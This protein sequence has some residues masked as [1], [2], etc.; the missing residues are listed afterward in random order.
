MT[1]RLIRRY[2]KQGYTI[3]ELWIDGSY[4]C[5]T[6]EP[7]DRSLTGSTPLKDIAKAK[8][9]GPTAIPSGRYQVTLNIVSP[10]LSKQACYKPCG[11]KVPRLVNVPGF[12]GILI[13]IGNWPSDTRGCILVGKNCVRGGMLYSTLAFNELYNR[14]K[15]AKNTIRIEIE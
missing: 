10:R 12:D 5:D 3:G 1:L 7:T 9:Q 13:H 14:L 4:F 6:L 11:G 15:E 8:E 2:K